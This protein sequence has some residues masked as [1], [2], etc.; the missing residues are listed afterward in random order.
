M[1]DTGV[2]LRC[3]NMDKKKKRGLLERAGHLEGAEQHRVAPLLDASFS[4]G[5][6]GRKR[7]CGTCLAALIEDVVWFRHLS[8]QVKPHENAVPRF[9]RQ[10]LRPP[11]PALLLKMPTS[12]RHSL[13]ADQ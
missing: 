10:E 3:C 7:A 4:T 8:P 13:S 11:P 1:A 6:W 9:L 5:G 2:R 12:S